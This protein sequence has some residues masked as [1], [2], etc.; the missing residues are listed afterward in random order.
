MNAL[1]RADHATALAT[2]RLGDRGALP[3]C[4]R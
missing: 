4:L 2:V 3:P 1:I